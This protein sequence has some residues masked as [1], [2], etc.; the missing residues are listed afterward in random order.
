MVS[1]EQS[2]TGSPLTRLAGHTQ[3]VHTTASSCTP[4][5]VFYGV[6][7]GSVLRPILF[8]LYTAD[9]LSLIQSHGVIPHVYADDTQIVQGVCRRTFC[10]SDCPTA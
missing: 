1:V 7:H 10:S 6:P 2:C 5:V 9:L 8:V 4:S 3:Y